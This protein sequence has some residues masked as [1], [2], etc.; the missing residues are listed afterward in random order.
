MISTWSQFEKDCGDSRVFGGIHFRDSVANT[1][2]IAHEAGDSAVEFVKKHL[3][4]PEKMKN[5][6]E[7]FMFTF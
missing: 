1:Y 6:T 2:S 3:N 7:F 4:Q 5:W